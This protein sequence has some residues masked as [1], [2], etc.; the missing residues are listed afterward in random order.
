MP[1]KL[2]FKF[3]TARLTQEADYILDAAEERAAEIN[4]RLEDGFV[5][6]QRT[7]LSTVR[8]GTS[9]QKSKAA[10][11]AGLTGAQNDAFIDLK[12]LVGRAKESAKRAFPGQD[13]KLRSEFQVGITT[14]S[15]LASVLS[16]AR[17]G[18]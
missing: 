5:A 6:R 15:D 16:R 3:P 12:D 14:P 8:G 13:V 7:L 18:A 11:V 10:D 4:P 1:V 2:Q 9:G 17:I